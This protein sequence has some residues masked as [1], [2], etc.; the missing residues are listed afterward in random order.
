MDEGVIIRKVNVEDAADVCRICCEDLGY[1]C[2]KSLVK[3][4]I[5]QLDPDRE[6]VFVAIVD[7]TVVGYVH[8]ERYNTLYF[9]TM[10]NILGIAVS[11]RIRR[12]GLGRALIERA[13]KWAEGNEIYL[14]RLSSGLGRKGAHEFYR[15]LGYNSEKEQI[16]FIKRISD[17]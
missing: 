13:E 2:D 17:M 12:H 10:A 7:D 3:E 4:R 8:V 11:G 5:L 6:A 15:R 9:E 14:M 1:Q 16:R